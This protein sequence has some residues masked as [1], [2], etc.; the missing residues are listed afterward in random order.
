MEVPENVP[1]NRFAFLPLVLA[2][3][4]CGTPNNEV[5]PYKD[6]IL[7]ATTY[8]EATDYCRNKGSTEHLLG[9]APAETGVLF[10]CE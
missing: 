3:G 8:N 4:G 9:K 10:K 5:I 2:I 6:G 7:R 1:M